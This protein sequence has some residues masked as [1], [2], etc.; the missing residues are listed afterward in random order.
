[1]QEHIEDGD[2]KTQCIFQPLPR[3]FAQRSIES[4]GNVLG[5]DNH[6]HDGIL[7]GSHVMVR[8]PELEA[9]AN[10]HVRLFH[11]GVRDFAASRDGLLPWVTANYANPSQDVLQS[12]GKRNVERLRS[13]AAKYDPS[14]VFQT[15]CPGGFKISSVKD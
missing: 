9:W 3:S 8:T 6:S 1:M 15:L 2:F 10:P 14:G 12:Y 7:W 13:A 11:E 5:I 4:G